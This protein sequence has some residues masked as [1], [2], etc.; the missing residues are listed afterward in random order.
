[1]NRPMNWHLIC[2][3]IRL[4]V[5]W[6]YVARTT[7]L[8]SLCVV[9]WHFLANF[10]AWDFQSDH[11]DRKAA[12]FFLMFRW[13]PALLVRPRALL[14]TVTL[15]GIISLACG[16]LIGVHLSPDLLR[17]LTS[18]FPGSLGGALA[19]AALVPGVLGS[20]VDTMFRQVE[21]SDNPPARLQS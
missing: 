20:A 10:F 9:L 5:A 12:M 13:M 17:W 1:M 18:K 6:R 21:F 2:Q 19:V 11:T 3:L 8:F 14:T 15:P 16:Y 7:I 4:D